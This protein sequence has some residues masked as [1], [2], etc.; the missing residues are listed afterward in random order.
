VSQAA[1][2][3]RYARAIFELGNETKQLAQVTDQIRK[4]AEVYAG[5]SDLRSVLDNPILD[6]SKR[7]GV[8]KDLGSRLGLSAHALNALRLL[9]SRHRLA[10]ITDVSAQLQR[11]ADDAA[12][13][14]R[15]TVISATHLPDSYYKDLVSRL[16]KAMSKK[17][18]LEKQRDPSLI[19]GV[20]TKI[21]DRTIDGSLK[22]RLETLERQLRTAS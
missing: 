10:A 11:L 13:V 19:A 14:V 18:L 2:A 12:G 4:F 3:E 6:E 1:I 15:A 20:V 17:I 21:G 8:L 9:A 7:E 5:S 22:G 16:E